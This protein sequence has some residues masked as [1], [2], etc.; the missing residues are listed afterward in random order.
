MVDLDE[1]NVS[2]EGGDV[3]VVDRRRRVLV[4]THES[5][6]EAGFLALSRHLKNQ[7]IEAIQVPH[8]MLHLDCC[9][10]PL[11]DGSALYTP[12]KLPRSSMH[13]LKG[14]FKEPDRAGQEESTKQLAANLLWIDPENVVSAEDDE[15][16]REATLDG[17]Q[18]PRHRIHERE[19]DVGEFPLHGVPAEARIGDVAGGRAMV[20]LGQGGAMTP[21]TPELKQAIEQA[22]MRRRNSSTRRRTRRTSS[23]ARGI[24]SSFP[25]MGAVNFPRRR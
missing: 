24:S 5:T 25:S 23:S 19:A 7:G 17:I 20:Y 4:G 3:M 14:L 13:L 16:Q 12:W 21:I 2:I 8:R 15:D 18:G 9:L 22:G 6:N 1:G 10:A 11:P